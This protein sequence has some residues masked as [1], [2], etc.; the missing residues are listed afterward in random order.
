MALNNGFNL[1]THTT[2]GYWHL[3]VY[4][5]ETTSFK[6]MLFLLEFAV[7]CII[8]TKKCFIFK[9]KNADSERQIQ[10]TMKVKPPSIEWHHSRKAEDFDIMTVAFSNLLFPKSRYIEFLNDSDFQPFGSYRTS[11]KALIH[12]WNPAHCTSP[13]FKEV[14]EIVT[15]RAIK[16]W[17]HP[18]T[19]SSSL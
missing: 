15:Y 1:M 7:L 4:L 9:L 17:N 3:H 19:Y 14:N 11:L 2:S 18:Y 6:T 8:I 12:S 5:D 13:I 16:S 10:H